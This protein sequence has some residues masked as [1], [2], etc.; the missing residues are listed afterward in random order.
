VRFTI[1]NIGPADA[2]LF[3]VLVQADPGLVQ[4]GMV[5]IASLASGVMTSRISLYH[6]VGIALIHIVEYV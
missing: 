1:F 3:K 6:L 4:Q 5:N 2:C